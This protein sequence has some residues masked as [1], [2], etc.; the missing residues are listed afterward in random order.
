MFFNVFTT[1]KYYLM[2][3]ISY[4][5][6]VKFIRKKKVVMPYGV[7]CCLETMHPT[8]IADRSSEQNVRLSESS[9]HAW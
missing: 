1:G 9:F 4:E 2:A 5:E 7:G 6:G 8:I 3:Y